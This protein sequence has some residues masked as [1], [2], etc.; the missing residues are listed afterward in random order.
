MIV[1]CVGETKRRDQT[2]E[3]KTMC[4]Y[5]RGYEGKWRGFKN[6]VWVSLCVSVYLCV[7]ASLCVYVCVS[8]W[9]CI[10]V[11]IPLVVCV[12]VWWGCVPSPSPWPLLVPVSSP[13][14]WGWALDSADIPQQLIH[15]HSQLKA[16][17][18]SRTESAL[19]KRKQRTLKPLMS[20]N[21]FGT[22]AEDRRGGMPGVALSGSCCSLMLWTSSE[23]CI[24]VWLCVKALFF[25]V[26]NVLLK[27]ADLG[28]G[29]FNVPSWK[30]PLE[31]P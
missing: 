28:L 19:R 24:L 9:M 4:R 3:K 15:G 10:S 14:G 8:L 20:K 26:F 13:F 12:C 25:K 30:S 16:L 23:N 1:K 21:Y 2:T 6:G 29:M 18:G 31:V 17:I 22:L 7:F 5:S 11:C 27:A